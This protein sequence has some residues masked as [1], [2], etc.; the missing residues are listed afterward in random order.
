MIGKA[1]PT[2]RVGPKG[3]APR[4]RAIRY[5]S[6]ATFFRNGAMRIEWI[7]DSKTKNLQPDQIPPFEAAGPQMDSEIR[8]KALKLA[9]SRLTVVVILIAV[10]LVGF[11]FRNA[12][13]THQ[14]SFARLGETGP[15]PYRN[16]IRLTLHRIERTDEI[17]G[18]LFNHRAK[19]GFD[20]LAV[21]LSVINLAEEAYKL[22]VFSLMLTT[23]DSEHY[24]PD[25][26]TRS[27]SGRLRGGSIRA[28]ETERGV[29][30]FAIPETK[31]PRLLEL[32]GA[33]GP[34]ASTSL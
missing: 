10:V 26:R 16:R 31:R 14:S 22:N 2:Q 11:K 29:V 7:Q 13:M 6:Q 21:E 19:K 23:E 8:R 1:P 28:Q 32:R 4:A 20:Y 30:V 9:V 24:T 3:S 33:T 5:N 27:V 25:L 17:D 15:S 12:M 18:F 34:L